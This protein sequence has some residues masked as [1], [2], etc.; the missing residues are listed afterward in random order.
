MGMRVQ[1]LDSFFLI[2]GYPGPSNATCGHQ[3][4]SPDVYF[5]I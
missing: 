3:C 5:T 2:I 1:K 4:N